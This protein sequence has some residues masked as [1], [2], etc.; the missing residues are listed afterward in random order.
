MKNLKINQTKKSDEMEHV[1]CIQTKNYRSDEVDY[2]GDQP[3][4]G[5]AILSI[6]KDGFERLQRC[7]IPCKDITRVVL[8]ASSVEADPH[9]IRQVLMTHIAY[10]DQVNHTNF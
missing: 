2:D 3:Y 1:Y 4:Q 5:E 8:A 7:G 10:V 9:I 6:T